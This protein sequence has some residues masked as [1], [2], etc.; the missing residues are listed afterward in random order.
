M[1]RLD[2]GHLHPLL[3]HPKMACSGRESNTG[4][5]GERQTLSATSYPNSL[6][7][8]MRNLYWSSVT[9]IRARQQYKR[10]LWALISISTR[11]QLI[12]QIREI[13]YPATNILAW[14]IYVQKLGG[15]SAPTGLSWT[16]EPV[17]YLWLK[18]SVDP[19]FN[20]WLSVFFNGTLL[21]VI[22]CTYT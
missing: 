21:F 15:F 17:A 13:Y 12:I 19:F 9:T 6:F 7:L 16:I 4:F 22:Y 3:K 10:V 14:R 5:S 20:W 2:Q 11:Q 1:E 8:A 18:L